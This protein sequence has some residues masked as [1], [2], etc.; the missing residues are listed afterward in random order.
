MRNVY[1]TQV[2]VTVSHAIQVMY[3]IAYRMCNA[4]QIGTGMSLRLA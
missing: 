2:P 1:T 4:V 3:L